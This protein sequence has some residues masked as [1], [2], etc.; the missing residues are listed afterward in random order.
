MKFKQ[1]KLCPDFHGEGSQ[2]FPQITPQNV[3]SSKQDEGTSWKRFACACFLCKLFEGERARPQSNKQKFCFF[4]RPQT[5]QIYRIV[6]YYVVVD[7]VDVDKVFRSEFLKALS[8]NV[9][10][11]ERQEA[12]GG[13]NSILWFHIYHCQLSFN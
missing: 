13:L 8:L 2:N 7:V 4:F 9:P 3:I 1:N 10:I 6:Y 5:R 12:V 11:I